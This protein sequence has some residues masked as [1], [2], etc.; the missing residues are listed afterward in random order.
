MVLTSGLL[1]YSNT[2]AG[3]RRRGAM[4]KVGLQ[5]RSRC[6]SIG[7]VPTTMQRKRQPFAVPASPERG[8]LGQ[9]ISRLLSAQADKNHG[10]VTTKTHPIVKDS[11][12]TSLMLHRI[13]ICYS[14]SA[15]VSVSRAPAHW[16]D[17][18]DAD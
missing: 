7:Q 11:S 18:V 4:S 15:E 8:P 14:P 3:R 2:W 6:N 10:Q 12:Q 13:G 1:K 16:G 17:P 9:R 5:Q